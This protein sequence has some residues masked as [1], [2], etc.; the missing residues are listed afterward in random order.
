MFVRRPCRV[1]RS[2]SLS[3]RNMTRKCSD[4]M[5]GS[6]SSAAASFICWIARIRL[7]QAFRVA[8]VMASIRPL[9]L[10][11]CTC[12]S[13][14]IKSNQ[15]DQTIK[16]KI[17]NHFECVKNRECSCTTTYTIKKLSAL[18]RILSQH[19]HRILA[20]HRVVGLL[21]LCVCVRA[22]SGPVIELSN[23]K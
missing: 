5:L 17:Q 6:V 18:G 14:T 2:D 7:D 3:S 8:S 10:I 23:G 1:R 20:G 12:S 22:R 13:K 9:S 19:L 4:R 11:A 15:N 16:T 21:G